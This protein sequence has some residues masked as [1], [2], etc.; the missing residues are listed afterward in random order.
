MALAETASIFCETIVAN[1][2][3]RTA[4]AAE[5]LAVLEHPA[6]GQL[7]DRG[8]HLLALPVRVT[9]VRG[10]GAPRAVGR[11][12]ERADARRSARDL[13]RRAQARTVSL[14]EIEHLLGHGRE[15]EPAPLVPARVGFSGRLGPMRIGYSRR[16]GNRISEIWTPGGDARRAGVAGPRHRRRARL[17]VARRC[18]VRRGSR[19]RWHALAGGSISAAGRRPSPAE[20]SGVPLSG[21]ILG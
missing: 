20:R 10:P 12:A 1:A 4:R 5:R 9:G 18:R 11:R 14:A 21:I 3:L 7:P 8:R 13:R 6:P 19:D 15:H 17:G 2:A 16:D